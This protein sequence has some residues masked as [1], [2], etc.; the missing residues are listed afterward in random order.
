MFKAF[1]ILDIAVKLE[2]NAEKIYRH[3]QQE[4]NDDALRELMQWVADE[5]KRHKEWFTNLQKQIQINEE[6][7]IIKEMSD[8]LLKDFVGKAAFSLEDAEFDK[9]KNIK[10]LVAVF[11]EFENDTI[12]FYELIRSFVTDEEAIA[13]LDQIILE[14]KQHIKRFEA[15]L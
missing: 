15:F 2:K 8:V 13:K 1:E 3:Q 6:D 11:I 5:E 12:L 4:M 9:I 14:E 7:A 10:D